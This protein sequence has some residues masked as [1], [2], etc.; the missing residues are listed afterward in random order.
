MTFLLLLSP[1]S[2][3]GVREMVEAHGEVLY[4]NVGRYKEEDVKK[5]FQAA[6]RLPGETLV[7]D[8]DISSGNALVKALHAFR[9][10]RP[11]A[12]VILLVGGRQVGDETISAMVSLGVYDLCETDNE[13]MFAKD[14]AVCLRRDVGTYAMASRWHRGFR[15]E[16]AEKPR[17]TVVIERRPVGRVT[18][19]VAGL[20]AGVG[21]THTAL[22]VGAFLAKTGAAAIV[23]D[24][25][26]P[27]FESIVGLATGKCRSARGFRFGSTDV[28]PMPKRREYEGYLYDQVIAELAEYDYVV[29]DLGVLD[30]EKLRELYRAQCAVIVGSASSW[31]I[32]DL[33]RQHNA[34]R[35]DFSNFA[36]VSPFGTEQDRR[37][38]KEATG[39]LPLPLAWC[40]DPAVLP[41]AGEEVLRRILG[42]LLPER[43]RQRSFKLF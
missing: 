6:A 4:E 43:K 25:Q 29:R 24:S 9:I 21:C 42:T 23:E 19:A 36:V 30:V 22:M 5:V 39:I 38:F 13:D 28:F 11:E 27:V 17:E 8:V 7:L 10:S 14:F 1:T 32:M 34:L 31:R 3:A 15:E 33:V 18:V 35:E 16:A 20:A 2:P 26:R 12:R 40:P 41:E 37:L